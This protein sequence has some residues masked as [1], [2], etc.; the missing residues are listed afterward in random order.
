MRGKDEGRGDFSF[1]PGSTLPQERPIDGRS[2]FKAVPGTQEHDHHQPA[3]F[4]RYHATTSS[5]LNI[6]L[7][8]ADE[9]D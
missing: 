5:R 2:P 6:L 8:I 1:A 9:A 4:S 7:R 3:R